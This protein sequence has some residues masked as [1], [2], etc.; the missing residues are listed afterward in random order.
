MVMMKGNSLVVFLFVLA[1]AL[2]LQLTLA[3]PMP[4][5][6][7]DFQC[8]A[9]GVD[10]ANVTLA[11]ALL[12]IDSDARR[13]NLQVDGDLVNG[14]LQHIRRCD[15]YPRAGW[16]SESWGHLGYDA[17][18]SWACSNTTIPILQETK[19]K[20]DYGIQ[21]SPL[22]Y[23]YKFKYAYTMSNCPSCP[24]F[25]L[26]T[27]YS[28]QLF[29][30]HHHQGSF[31]QLPESTKYLGFTEFN[32]IECEGWEFE[33]GEN[34]YALYVYNYTVPVALT[35]VVGEPSSSGLNTVYFSNFIDVSPPI[36][37]FDSIEGVSCPEASRLGL[38][39]GSEV[40]LD[41]LTLLQMA[42]TVS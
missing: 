18:S 36:E 21:P 20:C 38:K 16:Y 29:H 42:I 2:V 23:P 24:S 17:P 13:S 37:A 28:F 11:N 14:A 5:I 12:A 33:K 8:N 34:T 31:W 7:E 10:S 26:F 41:M 3:E 1:S 30:Y 15:L 9:T 25:L 27:L 40:E 4:S 32:G 22:L 19:D 35:K 6:S 39:V